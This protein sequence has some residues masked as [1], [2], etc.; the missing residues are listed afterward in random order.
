MFPD[1]VHDSRW[2]VFTTRRGFL[3]QSMLGAAAFTSR[4]LPGV[5]RTTELRAYIG[6]YTEG[7]ASEGLYHARFDPASGALRI[8]GVTGGIRNPSF[9]ALHPEGNNLYAVQEVDDLDA[10]K[11]GGVVAFACHPES[12]ALRETGR[13]SSGGAHPAHISVHPDGNRVLVANYS[14]G[15][16]AALPLRPGGAL[17]GPPRVARHQGSG[18]VPRRQ[19]APHPHAAYPVGARVY[20]PDLGT[21]RIVAYTWS[22]GGL[23][24][25]P[26][27]SLQLRPGD[28][29]RHM[30]FHPHAPLAFVINELSSS[31]TSLHVQPHTGA[32][33]PLATVATLPPEFS[34]ENSCADIHVHPNGRFLF[35]SNRGHDSIVVA[36]IAPGTGGLRVI[37]HHPTGGAWPRNFA[38]DPSGRFLLVA[39]QRTGTVVTLALEPA[40]GRL[41]D[42][43]HVLQVPAPVC[44]RFA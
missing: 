21:D 26:E 5:K 22:G 31:I 23:V 39:N 10:G 3:Q 35:G 2:H 11:S 43:G 6:T 8:T 16:V 19:E 18:P 29:P 1:P 37:Q 20:V 44:L 24:P 40:S 38:L 9:V 13:A 25:L 30:A 36:E 17:A 41:A 14:G 15:S 28:G 4:G 32:L 12:G 7:T 34:G 27:A 33:R 42:T